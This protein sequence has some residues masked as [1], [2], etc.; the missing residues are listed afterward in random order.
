[1]IFTEILEK[2]PMIDGW[3]TEKKAVTLA[4]IVIGMKPSVV[5]EVG[6]F[7]GKSALPMAMALKENGL[8]VIH[9]IDSWSAAVSVAGEE[10]ANAD[11]WGSLDHEA[12]YQKFVSLTKSFGVE[13]YCK[14][15]R[16]KSDDVKP[17]SFIDLFHCDGSHTDQAIK[18]VLRFAS[19]VRTGG[20]VVM[21]DLE[22]SGGG[23]KRAVQTLESM[24][25]RSL[26][27]VVGENENWGV[28]Q[29][30]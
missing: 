16:S 20:V 10:A 13:K 5:V 29:K 17:P 26:Y 30:I 22:W 25:F 9:C 6:V 11:W 24:G 3:C 12:I 14:I 27:T 4:S 21:D 1:M 19:R 8:G 2:F 23:V 7:G 15:H 18:D 28:F